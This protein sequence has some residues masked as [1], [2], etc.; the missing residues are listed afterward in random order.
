MSI[1][2][3]AGR[4]APQYLE[5]P[6]QVS[7]FDYPPKYGPRSPTFSR[8]V[9]LPLTRQEI[10]FIS[11]TASILGH[12]TMHGGDVMA[13]T[14]ETMRNISAL[15]DEASKISK[16]SKYTLGELHY[17]VYIRHAADFAA[18]RDILR[19]W[20]GPD[21]AVVYIQADVCRTYL[22]VEIEAMSLR[23]VATADGG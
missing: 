13:Q 20:V 16:G 21:S 15:L 22:L 9:L 17:R 10:L 6:R 7:A 18:V 4:V 3:M 19:Q 14:R 8:A 2:F 1:A 5:N 23:D 12:E 11:G